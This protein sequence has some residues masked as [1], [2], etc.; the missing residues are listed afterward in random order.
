MK[1]WYPIFTEFRKEY[2]LKNRIEKLGFKVYLPSFEK[3]IT[4]ARKVQVVPTPL[5]P[6]YLFVSFDKE[7]DFWNNL[8][9]LPGVHHFVQSNNECLGIN[10]DVIKKL[11][12][13]E[14]SK[15]YIELSN[16]LSLN[17]GTRIKF[18]NSNLKGLQGIFK[19]KINNKY[20]FLVS[21]FN[22]E[23]DIVLPGPFFEP[24]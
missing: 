7:T 18:S 17:K 2:Y 9:S 6:R 8:L 21:L 4:H 15:G 13:Y 14:N 22:R 3:T 12:T 1:K 19:E 10:D 16:F 5:F 11:R 23:F 24:V 20:K